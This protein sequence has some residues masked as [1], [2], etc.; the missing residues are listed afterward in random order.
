MPPVRFRPPE[1]IDEYRVLRPLGQGGMGTVFLAH[2]TLLDRVVAI[3]FISGG[4]SEAVRE[5]FLIEARAAAR[6]T[7]PH[8]VQVYR[9]GAAGGSPYLVSELVRGQSL[10]EL[11]KPVPALD[12]CR[13]ALGIARGLAALHERGVLHRDL[14]PANL[15]LAS[16][17]NVKILDFGIAKLLGPPM[18]TLPPPISQD[19]PVAYEDT[20][21]ATPTA[22]PPSEP[23]KDNAV[24]D[25]SSFLGLSAT[26]ESASEPSGSAPK[27]LPDAPSE[28]LTETGVLLG[29]PLYLAPEL[30]AGQEA[31]KRSDVYSLGCVLYQLATGEAPH[32]GR[33]IPEI[34]RAARSR[35]AP[36]VAT[37]ADG[38]DGRLATLIDRCLERDP[39]M[40]YS[41]GTEVRQALEELWHHK[42][43][44]SSLPEGNPYRGL[45][46]FEAEHRALFFGRS[47]EIE[48]VLEKVRAAPFVLVT[49]GSGVGKS[50]LARA[51]V[52]PRVA[53]GAL[54]SARTWETVTLCPGRHPEAALRSALS[55]VR[56]TL[57][58][59]R[60]AHE[61]TACGG[62]L[63]S[64]VASI[65]RRLG[66]NR[67]L[68]VFFDQLEELLT[69][70]DPNEAMAV[71]EALCALVEGAQGLRLLATARSDFLSRL[72]AMERFGDE[73]PSAVF[74]LRELGKDG[75]REAVIGPALTRGFRLESEELVV[76]LVERAG[77]LPLLQ[78]ALAL[79][80]DDRDL[81]RQVIPACALSKLGGVH[82]ALAHHADG[83]IAALGP[84]ER[85]AAR[86][87]LT[88]LVSAQGTRIPRYRDELVAGGSA[89][90]A[91]LEALVSGRLLVARES[92]D[93]LCAIEISH[94]ALVS[95]WGTLR[96]WLDESVE[97]RAARER[98]AAATAEW[99][100]LG[101]SPDVLWSERQLSANKLAADE[102][103]DERAQAFW[104][105]SERAHR[106][107][108][109]ARVALGLSIPLAA[110][111]SYAGVYVESR[112]ELT[113]RMESHTAEASAL[114][115]KARERAE[116]TDALRTSALALFD[117]GEIEPGEKAWSH[118]QEGLREVENG[119]ASAGRA[120]EAAL[121]ID[122]SRPELRAQFATFLADWIALSERGARPQ[123][124]R[125][126]LSRLALYDDSG[127]ETGRLNAP[128]R[129][130][131]STFPP[132]ANVTVERYEAAEGGRRRPVELP[133]LTAETPAVLS[134]SP[135]S[136]RLV[137]RAEGRAEVLY[138]IAPRAGEE[139]H[140]DVPLPQESL[141]PE[142]FVFVP[143][144]R[145]LFGSLDEGIRKT[146]LNTVPQHERR[147]GAFFIARHEV[148]YGDW[149][150]YL[151]ALPQAEA[152]SRLPRAG[153]ITFRGKMG[154]SKQDGVWTLTLQTGEKL[155][156]AKAAEPVVF[157][158][159]SRRKE[160][161]WRR[162][163]VALVS[164][165]DAFAYARW[166]SETGRIPGA[167]LCR[168]DEWERAARGADDR[169]YPHGDYLAPDD[170]NFDETYA[171]QPL[172]IGYDEVGSHPSSASPFGVEDLSGNIE[173]WTTPVLAGAYSSSGVS[174]TVNRS[175]VLRGGSWLLDT[176]TALVTNRSLADASFRDMMFGVR[177]CADVPKAALDAQVDHSGQE[178]LLEGQVAD[179]PA[180]VVR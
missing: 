21:C 30:W 51:G 17:G 148:T 144:G 172:A 24:L 104:T 178:P 168:E 102:D 134:L 11:P 112:R 113:S 13:I 67:G 60:G 80:W 97:S 164:G 19:V 58:G 125:D 87:I 23:E 33:S 101:K 122:P 44:A 105:A 163:P 143:E 166:R 154:L 68:L 3:K 61:D 53:E 90:A 135:G 73:V 35:D 99:E 169:V 157:A 9:V 161:D 46:R 83:V 59:P 76:S 176:S 10:E 85:K 147:T 174:T 115:Q 128:A 38:I 45:M 106:R 94:E 88:S 156:S 18:E 47:R 118:V 132:G 173:E 167:R 50:S 4:S 41:C 124:R 71:A 120:F 20:L 131:I 170:A 137:L 27:A 84:A 110:A 126:L 75:L 14:K 8:V 107:R 162:F 158:G 89:G 145:F 140:I 72:A 43:R 129:L 81:I 49:G 64:L 56:A 117:K 123:E 37:R 66:P 100:R 63:R 26:Q 95:G 22:P 175:L 98:L 40:R 65:A 136:H 91:A 36:K 54:G 52:L 103:M 55:A 31:T 48:A 7:H 108:R 74:V 139:L 62:D 42:E 78:F 5:R 119:Y 127:A 69:V 12:L 171:R 93:G 152:D 146:F 116:R 34:S 151:E 29:T 142:G 32:T 79:C 150:E 92:E 2:D 121:Q 39:W 155:V 159:R 1:Q 25:T 130:H 28:N 16:D 77:S 160:Q 114:H 179:R 96:V 70:A 141:V 82:G 177:L 57:G 6:L 138:P 86:S 153:D 165:E 149:I 133:A 180:I 111:L 15:M 109:R